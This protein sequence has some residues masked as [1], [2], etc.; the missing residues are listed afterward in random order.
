MRIPGRIADRPPWLCCMWTLST[1]SCLKN[2][3]ETAIAGQTVFQDR[4]GEQT[5]QTAGLCAQV[6]GK[7]I[8][9]HP[10][11]ENLIWAAAVPTQRCRDGI[12]NSASSSRKK[13][14]DRRR[15]AISLKPENRP[16]AI[17]ATSEHQGNCCRAEDYSQSSRGQLKYRGDC[18]FIL[19]NLKPLSR[20]RQY[21]A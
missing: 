19:L 18:R 11:E 20:G 3:I 21:V 4:R 5:H 8:L 12:R 17:V 6:L 9:L 16:V 7:R 15:P 10:A 13:V 14:Y 1:T 2:A